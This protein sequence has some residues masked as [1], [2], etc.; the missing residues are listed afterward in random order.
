MEFHWL[1]RRVFVPYQHF[2][3]YP[4]M[5]VARFNLYLQSGIFL[6]NGLMTRKKGGDGHRGRTILDSMAFVGFFLWLGL[7]LWHIPGSLLE[8]AVFFFWS[9]AVAGLLNVQITLSHFPR[10]IF[11][12][13][14]CTGAVSNVD[15][16]D[17]D[18]TK[19]SNGN[20]NID[21]V[22]VNNIKY[23]GDFYTRNILASLDV[24]CPRSLDWFHGGLQFQTLHHIYPRIGREH[25]RTIEPVIASL[26]K[27]HGLPYTRMTF[28]E[29]NLEV[30]RVLRE[31]ASEARKW[32]P[33]IY[34]AMCAHG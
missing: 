11:G 6:V 13:E 30:V 31:A 4:I 28:W 5:M 9:H 7:L 27:K 33:L 20:D 26:C 14:S 16:T 22:L 12:A 23:G 19:L 3:Y 32:S 10:P 2:W 15:E 24:S 8:K 1:A 29:C 34:E 21:K 17:L 25:L 18:I